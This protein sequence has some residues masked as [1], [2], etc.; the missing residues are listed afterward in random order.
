MQATLSS[1]VIQQKKAH[2]Y[3]I[4]LMGCRFVLTAIHE[5]PQ[6]AWDGIRALDYLLTRDEVDKN[7]LGVTGNSGGG[8][9]TT[10]L[11]G[12]DQRYTM[13]APSCFVTSFLRNLENELPARVP[14]LSIRG[15]RDN[16]ARLSIV[17]CLLFSER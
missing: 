12:L 7:H 10:W 2:H 15:C 13:A 4:K 6:I 9:L 5:D 14:F 11:A 1:P 3:V 8:T 17:K 16:S